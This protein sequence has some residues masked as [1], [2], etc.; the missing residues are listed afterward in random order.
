[1]EKLSEILHESNLKHPSTSISRID[2]GAISIYNGKLSK[3]GIK[4]N[5]LKILA[6]FEKTDAMFTDLLTESLKRNGF[7]DER[8]T[9]AVN[10]V[11][12][13]CRYPKPSIADFVSYDKSV[14]VY[15]WQDMVN[16]SFD[17]SKF[18]KIRISAEQSKPLYIRQEDFET[19]NFI[20]YE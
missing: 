19:N 14:K 8:F 7:T 16:N 5:C 18:V 10:Y 9:D 17:F 6:A 20:R 2:K 11:I 12:D 15:T 13:H 4:K 3:E 1:M